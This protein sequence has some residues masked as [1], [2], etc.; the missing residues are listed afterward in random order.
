VVVL[1]AEFL[2]FAETSVPALGVR[3][4]LHPDR[5]LLLLIL[6]LVATL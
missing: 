2:S 6:M 3:S 4:V 5:L 1:G